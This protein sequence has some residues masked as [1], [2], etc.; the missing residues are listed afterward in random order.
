MRTQFLIITTL[1][2]AA[3]PPA[4]AAGESPAGP[5]RYKGLRYGVQAQGTWKILDRDGANRQVAPYLSSLGGGE[6]GTGVIASPP[7]LLAT[8]RVT[9]TIC[10]HDG[11]GG[12]RGKNFLALVDAKTG[13]FLK[14]TTAPGCDPMKEQTWDVAQIKG[15]KVRIEVRDGLA[16]GAYAW[17]GIGRID[18]GEALKIE[19]GAGMPED[20]KV[21]VERTEPKTEVLSGGVPFLRCPAA[22]TIVPAAGALEI[23]CG[24]T[25]ERI[26]LL[27]CTLGGGT[28]GEVYGAVTIEYRGGRRELI[29][30]MLGFTLDGQGKILSPSKAI[31][32]HPS[33]DPFQHYLV[34][35]PRAELIE[36]ITLARNSRQGLVPRVTAITF[37]TMAE[38][39]NL[40]VLP[41]TELSPQEAAWIKSHAVSSDAPD[42]KKITAE[43]HRAHRIESDP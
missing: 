13:D 6:A 31:H 34:L 24:F 32:L 35:A 5:A 10:G 9:F 2:L 12:G 41:A 4:T 29:P 7:F 14:K 23:P 39:E 16:E 21:T 28:P 11:Q 42:M 19:F 36:K 17:M 37:R 3:C 33:P 8:D 26:F 27:G 1:L 30:L 22:Y 43:I 15:R 20:W 25:A 40:A 38:A 18:A